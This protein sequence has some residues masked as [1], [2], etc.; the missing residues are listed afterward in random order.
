MAVRRSTD[1]RYGLATLYL[2]EQFAL[3]K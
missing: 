2:K 1:V 3:G